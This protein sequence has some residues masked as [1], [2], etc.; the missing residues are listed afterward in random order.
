ML[1][2]VNSKIVMLRPAEI[3]PCGLH[4]RKHFDECE[5]FSLA[6]SIRRNGIIQP[7]IVRKSRAGGYELIAGERRLRAAIMV[8]IRRIPCVLY[9]TDNYQSALYAITEN[10]H[11][12]NLNFFEQSQAIARVITN[13]GIEK[14]R[15][16]LQLGISESI[17]QDKLLLL[18]IDKKQREKIIKSGLTEKHAYALLRLDE[19]KRGRALDRIILN[20]LSVSQTEEYIEHLLNP[21][22]IKEKEPDKTPIRKMVISDTRLFINS[23]NKLINNMVDSGVSA[24]AKR[25]ESAKHIEYTIKISKSSL[26]NEETSC[27][28]KIC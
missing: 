17:L 22:L 3:Q 10:F 15:V 5:L 19:D 16:A 9:S 20:D 28:L 26:N 6:E 1:Q 13:F 21:P 23:L 18:R 24:T 14:S 12:C 2:M 7:L 27:Q 8:G 4:P 25:K 11:R